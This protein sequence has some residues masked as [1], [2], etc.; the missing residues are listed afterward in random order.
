MIRANSGGRSRRAI[1][2]NGL[3]PF[4]RLIPITGEK[5]ENGGRAGVLS[6]SA[7]TTN[8]HRSIYFSLFKKNNLILILKSRIHKL[9]DLKIKY[10]EREQESKQISPLGTSRTERSGIWQPCRTDKNE[11]RVWRFSPSLAVVSFLF[12]FSNSS[13]LR[14][15]KV[16]CLCVRLW[17]RKKVDFLCKNAIKLMG[18]FVLRCD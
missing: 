3:A 8:A 17:L 6:F 14:V 10:F 15:S 2:T 7:G 1:Q 13:T 11:L 16:C 9:E 5:V 4:L 18:L 12:T